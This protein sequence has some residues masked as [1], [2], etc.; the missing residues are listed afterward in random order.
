M[1]IRR[2]TI[3]GLTAVL[4]AAPPLFCQ[5]VPV[6]DRTPATTPAP[7]LPAPAVSA[8]LSRGSLVREVVD[9][10]T[11]NR[12]LLERDARYPG[13][14]GRMVLAG[15]PVAAIEN[16]KTAAGAQQPMAAFPVIRAGDLVMLVAHTAAMDA[17]LEAVALGPAAAGDAF[18]ARLK[19]GGA[20]VNA[21]AVAHGR[22]QWLPNG[23]ETR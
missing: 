13:G 11:G 14:P 23:G 19:M 3:W 5:T 17:E 16:G 20:V 12:W 21:V 7:A 15:S 2:S 18:R 10:A 8:A 6:G 1:K 22:A 9:P 4:L